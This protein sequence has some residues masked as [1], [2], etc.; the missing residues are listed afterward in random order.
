M[1]FTVLGST[2]FIGKNLALYLRGEGHDVWTPERGDKSILT[3]PLGHVFYCIGLTADFRTKPYDTIR[4][5]VCL[6]ADVLELANFDSLI[7]LSS[8]RVYARSQSATEEITLEVDP[9][10]PSDLYNLS[11][12]TGESLCNS[13]KNG[14][15]KVVR[16]SNVIG[17]DGG[18]NFMFELIREA[19]SGRIVL[20]S[21][22]SSSKDY[23]WVEDVVRLLTQVALEGQ[24][25]LYNI[26]SG[27]NVL[28][29]DIVL[30]ISALTGCSVDVAIGAL[31]HVFPL[32]SIDRIIKEFNFHPRLVLE[33][34]HELIMTPL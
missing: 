34:I 33:N 21:A 16:L 28:H 14:V 19:H 12:L 32:I 4:A 24:Y 30:H 22:L 10:N 13:S 29:Q 17:I 25:C 20:K 6:L 9:K 5:H 31:P 11:K 8:T 2:G 27:I 23:I 7:Y 18:K 3:R 1:K 15:I 26:A